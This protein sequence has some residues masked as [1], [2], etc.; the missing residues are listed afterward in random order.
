M[1]SVLQALCVQSLVNGPSSAPEAS[2]FIANMAF[3]YLARADATTTSSLS[4]SD[5][6]ATYSI[7]GIQGALLA[8]FL[9]PIYISLFVFG[10]VPESLRDEVGSECQRA[11]FHRL[12]GI[13]GW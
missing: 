1:D 2:T 12:Q 6:L 3:A 13:E 9:Q 10:G 4:C 7:L 8:Y 11:L 5:K